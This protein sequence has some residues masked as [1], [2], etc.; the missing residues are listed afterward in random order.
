[1]NAE[2]EGQSLPGEKPRWCQASD[3]AILRGFIGLWSRK[4]ESQNRKPNS[5]SLIPWRELN[6]RALP[7]KALWNL[8]I[9]DLF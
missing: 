9:K 7:A 1:M 2:E 4:G 6:T 3:F 8:Y 5:R